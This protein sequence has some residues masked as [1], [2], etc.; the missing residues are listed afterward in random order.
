MVPSKETKVRRIKMDKKM[1]LQAKELSKTFSNE[2]VQQHVLKNLNLKIY[3]GDFTVIMGNSGSGKSTLLYSLSGMDRPSLGTVSYYLGDGDEA[4]DISKYS[5]DK[6]ALFRRNHAGF[7]FQQNYLN[8]SMSALD[9]VM[10][11]GL[12]KNK[13]RKELAEKA[14]VPKRVILDMTG[15][16]TDIRRMRARTVFGICRALTFHPY[17]L[18]GLRDME[19]YGPYLKKQRMAQEQRQARKEILEEAERIVR[20]RAA[21]KDQGE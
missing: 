20:E 2:S 10:I 9:N 15:G 11:S 3:K 1:I 7:V 17:F 12:L 18:Y 6:L 13:N 8:D 19:E 5:N 4:T 21:Q 16:R 14:G